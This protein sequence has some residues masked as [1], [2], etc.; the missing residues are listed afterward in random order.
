[1]VKLN[2]DVLKKMIRGIINTREDEI[3]CDEC[4]DK[5]DRFI[6]LELKGKSPEE[7]LPL[8]KDHLD[9]CKDCRE[10]YE[11]L[12]DAIKKLDVYQ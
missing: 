11:A 6:E 8:V 1:M 2:L 10:E 5:L 7:A 4:F 12:L 9:R 3:G